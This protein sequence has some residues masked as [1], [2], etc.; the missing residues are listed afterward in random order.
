ME[1]PNTSQQNNF[2]QK[3]NKIVEVTGIY[4][5]SDWATVLVNDDPFFEN[6]MFFC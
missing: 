6:K 3:P 1:N 5:H 4:W 2:S